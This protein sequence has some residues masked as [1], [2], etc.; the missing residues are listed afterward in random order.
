MK[1][2]VPYRENED[3]TR[4]LVSELST[5]PMTLGTPALLA[6][7]IGAARSG[8]Y[9]GT[10]F[11]TDYA[12]EL[13]A[14]ATKSSLWQDFEAGIVRFVKKDLHMG[15]AGSVAGTQR[16]VLKVTDGAI[17][18]GKAWVWYHDKRVRHLGTAYLR[19]AAFQ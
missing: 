15:K 14:G 1:E 18:R 13:P 6:H 11:L 8:G 4:R 5:W 3:V 10:E 9:A 12:D 19:A 16:L 17:V 7:Y 2:E